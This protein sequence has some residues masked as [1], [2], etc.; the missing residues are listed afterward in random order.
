[1]IVIF[2]LGIPLQAKPDPNQYDSKKKAATPTVYGS[3]QSP[4]AL[5]KKPKE[6]WSCALCQISATNAKGLNEHLLGRKHKA[7]EAPLS[8]QKI[9]RARGSKGGGI[10]GG[11]RGGAGRGY[12][13]GKGGGVGGGHGGG[14]GGGAGG[15]HGGGIGARGGY[16]GGKGGGFGGVGG[17]HGGGSGGVG[18][19]MQLCTLD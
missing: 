7:K 10:G 17:E 2:C 3:K 18:A 9:G 14:K 12:G 4:L 13:G 19:S 11:I 15:G 16:G 8:T 6:E 5:K 1:M